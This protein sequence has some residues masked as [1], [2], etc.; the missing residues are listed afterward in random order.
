MNTNTN[1]SSLNA[2]L[3]KFEAVEANLVKLERIWAEIEKMI[4]DGITFGENPVHEGRC[5]TYE[6]ILEQLPAI[7]GWKPKELPM[8]LDDIA[9]NRFDAGEI[10]EFKY[11]LREILLLLEK[12]FENIVSF[13]TS[14]VANLFVK[15]FF[16]HVRL[17]TRYL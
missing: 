12:N 9:Q 14:S 3:R 16:K 2:A 5:R 7:E 10:G 4:P 1:E 17:S 15:Q 11:Q 13:S 8:D 6:I